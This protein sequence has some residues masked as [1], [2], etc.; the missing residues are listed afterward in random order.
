MAK[1]RDPLVSVIIPTYKRKEKLIRCLKSVL[2][3]GFKDLEVIVVND[4]P[5]ED[6]SYITKMNK[7]IK[8]VQNKEQS[9]SARSRMEGAN[10]SNGKILYFIDDD[11]ILEKGAIES[12][13][14]VVGSG[15]NVGI[16]TPLMYDV[17]GKI[18]YSGIRVHR[19]FIL[20][21]TWSHGE[22]INKNKLIDTDIIINTYMID[23]EL[24]FRV[25]GWEPENFTVLH[26]DANFSLKVKSLGYNNYVCPYAHTVHDTDHLTHITP[27][28]IYYDSRNSTL[29]QYRY[30]TRIEFL[31][32]LIFYLP[33]KFVYNVFYFIPFKAA[34][35]KIAMY[36]GY[37]KGVI[38]GFL[39]MGR[40][41]RVKLV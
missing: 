23:R 29:L 3:N 7:R 35:N 24:F 18:W 20:Q 11:N 16:V 15:K 37:L 26:E 9:L 25:G 8:L 12:L 22:N 32:F 36:K 28:R 31:L 6:I 38:D 33:R 5:Q 39:A 14:G 17:G 13:V 2:E 21:N 41:K 4:N 10:V 19:P 27:T 30:T 1:T 34:H 40:I